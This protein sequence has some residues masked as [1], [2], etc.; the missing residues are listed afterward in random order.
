VP[1]LPGCVPQREALEEADM[2]ASDAI[3]GYYASLGKHRQSVPREVREL[4]G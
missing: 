3:K 4:A 1:A 2:M